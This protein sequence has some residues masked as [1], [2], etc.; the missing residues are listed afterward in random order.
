MSGSAKKR[1]EK[2]RHRV[3]RQAR[4]NER[5]QRADDRFESFYPG[6]VAVFHG[7]MAERVPLDVVHP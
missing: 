1:R 3:R 6:G 4:W 7:I 5:R 2:A